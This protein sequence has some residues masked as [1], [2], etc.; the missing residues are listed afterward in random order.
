[1]AWPMQSTQCSAMIDFNQDVLPLLAA[2]L[3]SVFPEFGWRKRGNQ[4]IAT[5]GD[6][7]RAHFGARPD[8]VICYADGAFG[9]KVHGDRFYTW[10]DYLG[11]EYREM[12]EQ[13]AARAGITDV[14]I[15]NPETR[16][17]EPLSVPTPPSEPYW[18]TQW[19]ERWWAGSMFGD[20]RALTE[21]WQSYKPV[22]SSA[23]DARVLGLGPL[24]RYGSRCRDPRLLVP[25][26]VDGEIACVRGRWL[27]Y[28]APCAPEWGE[29]AHWMHTASRF[30]NL[31][32][33]GAVIG[34]LEPWQRRAMGLCDTPIPFSRDQTYLVLENHVDAV[35]AEKPGIVPLASMCGAGAWRAEWS[36][37][38]A[39]SSPRLIIVMLDY[40]QA[41]NAP[42]VVRY[43]REWCDAA[44]R[45][46]LYPYLVPNESEVAR[47]VA[48]RASERP[49]LPVAEQYR[50]PLRS[51]GARIFAQLVDQLWARGVLAE[52]GAPPVIF[53]EWPV[54]TPFKSDAG[55]LLC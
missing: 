1:M 30:G 37:V 31:L 29:C 14:E 33:N 20:R 21:A 3:D 28:H 5:N 23:I 10:A 48:W 16:L 51:A 18:Y 24:P 4:W 53:Y 52:N 17:P 42:C 54:G 43:R 41:G 6:H 13:V 8:R 46:A 38:L 15:K 55:D 47:L 9:L 2:R 50:D 45:E 22:P 11:V 12:I 26:F 34:E 32:W 35:L 40:D 25:W 39:G 36:A 44:E 49:D 7:T 27:R 19:D